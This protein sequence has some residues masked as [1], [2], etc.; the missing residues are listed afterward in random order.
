MYCNTS[1]GDQ[2]ISFFINLLPLFK[3][4]TTININAINLGWTSDEEKDVH[5]TYI[6]E[7]NCTDN[8]TD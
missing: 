5:T 1:N 7:S 6:F 8:L 2:P 4:T 3:N